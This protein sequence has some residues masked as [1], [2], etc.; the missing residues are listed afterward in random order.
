MYL[1]QHSR[2]MHPL[3]VLKLHVPGSTAPFQQQSTS[4]PS[5]K[6]LRPKDIANKRNAMIQ[7]KLCALMQARVML[8]QNG[9]HQI[10]ELSVLL[11]PK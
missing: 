9:S 4:N 1:L 10:S 11:W 6:M 8:I 3:T 7:S 5:E 2:D